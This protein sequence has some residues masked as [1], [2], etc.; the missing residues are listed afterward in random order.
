M[1]RKKDVFC[2]KCKN[3]INGMI[4]RKGKN[5]YCSDCMEQE[6]I[7]W[8]DWCNLYDYIKKLYRVK[9]VSVKIITQLKRY[10]KETKMTDYG[11]L[12][13]LIYIYDINNTTFDAELNSVGLIPYYYEEANRYFKNKERISE[14]SEYVNENEKE[15]DIVT[16]INCKI[17]NNKKE[18]QLGGEWEDEER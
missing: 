1:A 6:D 17:D 4:Y 12:N 18:L 5:T 3:D 7:E 9:Q 10:K 14:Q 2:Y 16:N 11:M 13:T 8:F 15:I